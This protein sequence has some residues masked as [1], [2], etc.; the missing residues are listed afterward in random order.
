MTALIVLW[1]VFGILGL[2]TYIQSEHAETDDFSAGILALICALMF[3]F[4]TFII[5]GLWLYQHI[6]W[7]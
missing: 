3:A 6:T 4:L 7:R 1:I 5:A 2:I